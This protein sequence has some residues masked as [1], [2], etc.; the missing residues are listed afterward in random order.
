[1]F[2]GGTMEAELRRQGAHPLP[3][4]GPCEQYGGQG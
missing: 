3:H 4:V 2:L 1:M